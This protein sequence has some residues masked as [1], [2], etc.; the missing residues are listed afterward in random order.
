MKR[1]AFFFGVFLLV[2]LTG[3]LSWA[4]KA[5]VTDSFKI[6]LRSGPSVENKII[7]VLTS[8]QAV[9]IL[10]TKGDWS[11]VQVQESGGKTREGWV[12]G[13]YLVT[14][15]PWEIQADYYKRK[16]T[17]LE[18]KLSE[19]RESLN[20]AIDE[21]R[22]LSNRLQETIRTLKDLQIRHENLKKGAE[23]YLELRKTHKAAQSLLVSLRKELQRL[24]KENDDLR[25]SQMNKWFATGAL[26]LL[27]GLL[28]GLMVGRQQRR[29]RSLY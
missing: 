12:L 7:S 23:G 10:E 15:V 21:N 26:V 16:N 20:K 17:A 5:Y 24:S 25:A 6:T 22:S 4:E 8:A 2:C 18:K 9:E 1:I 28:I 29:R 27:C 14:R 13:R 3:S 19:T 11:R